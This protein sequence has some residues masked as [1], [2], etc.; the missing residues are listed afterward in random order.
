MAEAA[1]ERRAGF[2]ERPAWLALGLNAEKLLYG[3]L[4]VVAVVTR[5]W[6][7]GARVM[8]H[9]E[10]LHTQFS[11]YLYAGRGFQHSPLMHGPLLFVATAVNYFLFGANDYTARIFPAVIGIVLALVIPWLLRPW[12]GRWGALASA[13]LFVISPAILYH[14]RYI[15]HDI[16]VIT[17]AMIC[18]V[19]MVY[20]LYKPRD[21][22]LYW[23]AAG[24]AL[25]FTTM[26]TAYI[27]T[28]IFGAF[29]W[30]KLGSDVLQV[31]WD[32]PEY[33]MPFR[34][35]F[36]LFGAAAFGL[37]VVLGYQLITGG[38]ASV[39]SHPLVMPLGGIAGLMALA[40]LILMLMGAWTRVRQLPAFHLFVVIGTLALPLGAALVM[41]VGCSGALGGRLPCYQTSSA[42]WNYWSGNPQAILIPVAL[43]IIAGVFGA[44]WDW[45]RWSISFFTFYAIF[46]P[47]YTTLFTWGLGV[48]TGIVGGLGYWIEQHEVVRGGQPWYYYLWLWPFYE[49]L[50]ILF[51]LIAL[52]YLFWHGRGTSW[53]EKVVMLPIIGIGAPMLAALLPGDTLRR[54]PETVAVDE[55]EA[56][57]ELDEEADEEDEG[58][59]PHPRARAPK[60]VAVPARPGVRAVAPIPATFLALVG[61]LIWMNV[62]AYSLAGEKMPWLITHLTAPTVLLAGWLVGRLLER[63]EWAGVWRRGGW[64]VLALAPVLGIALFRMLEMTLFGQA[65]FRGMGTVELT[66]TSNWLAAVVLAIAAAAGLV[67]FTR[68]LRG[69]EA[70]RLVGVLAFVLGALLTIRTSWR[71]AYV[72]YDLAREFMVYAH[73]APAT[74]QVMAQIEEMSLRLYGDHSIKVAYDDDVSWPFTWYLRPDEYPNQT[75]YGASPSKESL[76][77][78]VVL[79]GDK[80]YAKVEPFLAGRYETFEYIFLWWP[81]EDYK[82]LGRVNNIFTNVNQ[83]T[84]ERDGLR[85]LWDLWFYRDYTRYGQFTGTDYSLSKWPVRHSFKM[86][87]R[88]DVAARFWDYGAEQVEVAP[89]PTDACENNQK[90]LNTTLSIAG[91]GLVKPRGVAVAPDG[92]IVVVDS[93][94][95]RIVLFNDAGEQQAVVTTAGTRAFQ[96]PWGVAVNAEGEIYVADT[97]NHR[98]V[99]LDPQGQFVNEWGGEA[100]EGGPAPGNEGKF[101]GPRGIAVGPDGRVYVT[102]TGNK[103][104]QVFNADGSFAGQFGQGGVLDGNFDEPVGIALD[105]E[106]N[107]YVADTWNARVQVFSPTQAFVRSWLVTGWY[108]QGLDN[109][110]Y[111]AV[112]PDGTVYVTDPERSRVIGYDA[113]GK[114]T[115]CWGDLAAFGQADGVAVDAEGNV[116]VSDPVNGRVAKFSTAAP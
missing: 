29:L 46:I 79:A 19:A 12:L 36:G 112:G 87:V 54:T 71:F 58:D 14:S 30:L 88:K 32:N 85:A 38:P 92:T 48:L 90:V 100:F 27:Y 66:N 25:M 76:D 52:V 34:I 18:L 20:Y 72:T 40:A 101:W 63:I 22:H 55:D 7:L 64:A 114:P 49:W 2:W 47:L 44:L 17:F 51:A 97:W 69:S 8:S 67:Q 1:L 23:L 70:L 28:A 105:A 4:F 113:Q 73:G 109:K 45:K 75:F 82:D 99:H 9:D 107:I 61:F 80:N 78:P 53:Y 10:S 91:A 102:D 96:E 24:M 56:D 106:G 89:P 5:F 43:Y 59:E 104:V 37:V 98:I 60:V 65:P 83:Q 68:A 108:G 31:K 50:V 62:F 57:D 110:P 115:G 3:L 74:K 15:R 77:A 103:R 95:N 42:D 93:G 116:V 11:W 86:Y 33:R 111:L 94:N 26:E 16:P 35:A 39:T 41:R 21:R 13:F 84:G 6:D 81:I